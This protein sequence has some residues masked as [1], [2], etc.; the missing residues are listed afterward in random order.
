MVV[1]ISKVL[2]NLMEVLQRGKLVPPEKIGPHGSVE[3][4][5]IAVLV[6]L[7]WSD[8]LNGD[9]LG[10][11]PSGQSLSS[12]LRAVIAANLGR[13]PTYSDELVELLGH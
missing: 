7:E 6:T 1:L 11:G 8:V 9:A 12:K 4:L 3:A 5:Y 13:H 10:T 2:R